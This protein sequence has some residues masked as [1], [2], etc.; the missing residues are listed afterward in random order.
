MNV[1]SWGLLIVAIV[2]L[3]FSV[4]A[5]IKTGPRR[6]LIAV[7]LVFFGLT[8]VSTSYYSVPAGN[9]GVLLRFGAVQG[10]L[11]EG[12]HLVTPF[13]QSVELM[14]VRTQMSPSDASAASKDLQVVQT[15]VA[16]NY[17]LS[18]SKVG[19]IFKTVGTG[20]E[21][22]IIKPAVQETVKSA[23][24]QYTAQQLIEQREQVKN[25]IDTSLSKRLAAYNI[26][27]E[28]NG[29]SLTNFD[30]SPKFNE[31][32]EEKQAAQQNALKAGYLLTQ[33]EKEAQT[34]IARAKGEAESNRLKA[35]A[36]NAKGG[37]QVIQLAWIDA[38]SKGGAQVPQVV[39]GGG[40][41]F[42]FNLGDLNKAKTTATATP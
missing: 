25:K 26:I 22:A 30:F 3:V 21:D 34:A 13:V 19:D 1:F 11:G 4:V 38:W 31:A 29:V 2:A 36:L 32:I 37:S 8:V 18:P 33:A 42:M 16:I 17:H 40:S 20:Y 15:K 7:A 10:E 9:R 5:D 41:G 12:F 14:N 24:A 35:I 6:S 28:P 27:V 39:S 23:V